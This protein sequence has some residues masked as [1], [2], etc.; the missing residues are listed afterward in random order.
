MVGE[1]RRIDE[2]PS[3]HTGSANERETCKL[4]ALTSEIP[5]IIPHNFPTPPFPPDVGMQ[6]GPLIG[7]E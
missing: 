2:K 7:E 6:K 3:C 5:C 1:G 4:T